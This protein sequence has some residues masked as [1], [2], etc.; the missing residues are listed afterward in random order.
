MLDQDQNLMVISEATLLK[1]DLITEGNVRLD[2]RVDGLIQ[3]SGTIE[4]T[5]SGRVTGAIIAGAVRIAGHVDADVVGIQGVALLD[6]CHIKGQIFTKR[7]IAGRKAV[8]SAELCTGPEAIQHAPAQLTEMIE[9]I[10]PAKPREADFSSIT[11]DPHIENA[12]EDSA[13][14]QGS[15]RQ[16]HADYEQLLNELE[17]SGDIMQ[18]HPSAIITTNN[19]QTVLR[20]KRRKGTSL[21]KSA[22][23]SP[24]ANPTKQPDLRISA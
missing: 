21:T 3:S 4:I 15:F 11:D 24:P 6:G 19:F 12:N 18:N 14:V 2:G 5:A 10:S 9:N 16:E 1:G 22:S 7:L 20:R 8:V 17:T 23:S 13:D